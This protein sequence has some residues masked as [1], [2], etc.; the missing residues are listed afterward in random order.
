MQQ[1]YAF[2]WVVNCIYG[3]RVLCSEYTDGRGPRQWKH[4]DSVPKE[5]EKRRAREHTLITPAHTLLFAWISKNRCVF[6]C[7]ES[8]D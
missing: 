5:R 1:Y 7:R 8:S 4:R 2:S 6:L 3:F